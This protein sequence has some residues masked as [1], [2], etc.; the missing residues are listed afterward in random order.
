MAKILCI[1]DEEPL[2]R[3]IAGEI[4]A[5]GYPVLTAENGQAGLQ[6]ILTHKPDLILCDIMMPDMDGYELLT[7]LRIYHPEFAWTPFIFLTALADSRDVIKG[8][9]LGADDYLTKPVDFDLLVATLESR[10]KR[11][12]GLKEA[13]DGN[14]VQ[15][16]QDVTGVVFADGALDDLTEEAAPAP[17][18]TTETA[19]E[20]SDSLTSAA[21]LA[22]SDQAEGGEELVVACASD[23]A[24]LEAL[25]SEVRAAGYR[26]ESFHSG[27]RAIKQVPKLR[28]SA[29]LVSFRTGDLAGQ[30]VGE[31]LGTLLQGTPVI[32]LTPPELETLAD[33]DRLP[34]V[35]DALIFPGNEGQLRDYLSGW[36]QSA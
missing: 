6:A 10:L 20:S 17:P 28:P 31:A 15:L 36:H 22:V 8:K 27:Q 11:I 4:E 7:E 13:S 35:T 21:P 26:F 30:L 18:E 1:D 2:R 32:F 9:V 33:T 5:A 23:A 19:Q 25:E 24:L 29:V 3:L 14:A 12:E 34:G 16:Y